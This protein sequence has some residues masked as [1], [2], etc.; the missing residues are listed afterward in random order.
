MQSVNEITSHKF[1]R[2]KKNE[3]DKLFETIERTHKLFSK[4]GQPQITLEFCLKMENKV[5]KLLE[6]HDV[7]QE[8]IVKK[9]ESL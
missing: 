9:L 5:T 8:Y 7:D 1:D 4:A 6:K 2:L 3:L